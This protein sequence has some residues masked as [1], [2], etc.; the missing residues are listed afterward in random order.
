MLIEPFSDTSSIAPP[1]ATPSALSLQEPGVKK[2]EKQNNNRNNHKAA[3]VKPKS[4]ALQKFIV[5]VR[6][7]N[8]VHSSEGGHGYT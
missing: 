5:I 8:A 1:P 6:V 4:I 7:L 2:T 3:V